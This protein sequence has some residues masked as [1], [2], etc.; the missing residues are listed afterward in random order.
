[1]EQNLRFGL[2][3]GRLAVLKP[4]QIEIKYATFKGNVFE[5]MSQ[6]PHSIVGCSPRD[7][8]VMTLIKAC[9][10]CNIRKL[11]GKNL[12]GTVY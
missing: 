6:R 8:Y 3:L 11:D 4:A 12:G 1:M 7:L 9:N 10:L 5:E 2:V